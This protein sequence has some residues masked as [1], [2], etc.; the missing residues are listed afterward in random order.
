MN[1]TVCAPLA[2]ALALVL[3]TA[4]LLPFAGGALIAVVSVIIVLMSIGWVRLLELPS[5]RGSSAI[6]ALTGLAAV[7]ISSLT[8]GHVPFSTLLV[9]VI[10]ISLFLSFFHEMLRNKRRNLT[11]SI[12]G[13][14]SGA[15]LSVLMVSWLQAYAV[16]ADAGKHAVVLMTALTCAVSFALIMVALP[17]TGKI[18]IPLAI[19]SA[20]VVAGLILLVMGAS[21]LLTGLAALVGTLISTAAISVF[22]LVERVI[23]AYDTVQFLALSTSLLPMVGLLEVLCVRL[24]VQYVPADMG[25]TVIPAA[26]GA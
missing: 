14:A 26:F 19:I 16:A 6:I 9:T 18:R 11:L 17:L 7:A 22:F 5:P 13:T 20:T 10:A 23:G 1:Q 15:L 24:A 12:S 25:L 2:G 8:R 3:A 4:I 21:L